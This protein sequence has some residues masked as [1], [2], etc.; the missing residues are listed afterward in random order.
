MSDKESPQDII[1]AYRKRQ[2]RAQRMPVVLFILFAVLIVVGG[3][4]VIFW[5]TGAE[6]PQI[7]MDMFDRST[8]TPTVTLTYTST[9]LPPTEV[10]EPASCD[11]VEGS[12]LELTFDG[13][14]CIYDGPAQQKTGT[15]TV[16]FINQSDELAYMYLMK[17]TGDEPLQDSSDYWSEGS[18]YGVPSWVEYI[19]TED[20]SAGKSDFWEGNLG[21]GINILM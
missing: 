12:C 3:A 2:E 20:A 10:P 4:F 11:E 5:L 13:E 6:T 1:N 9:P 19:F 21:S 14:N 15:A 17:H 8:E 7:S 16:F 18:T